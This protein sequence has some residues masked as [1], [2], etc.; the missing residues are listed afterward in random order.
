MWRLYT[1]A[2]PLHASA[3]Y[4]HK[5]TTTKLLAAPTVDVNAQDQNFCTALHFAAFEGHLDCLKLIADAKGTN[6]NC[7]DKVCMLSHSFDYCLL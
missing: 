6:I 1:G 2:T 5:G 7:V 4:G 3:R